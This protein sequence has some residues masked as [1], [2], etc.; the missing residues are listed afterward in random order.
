MVEK[1]E[2]KK[3]RSVIHCFDCRWWVQKEDSENLGVCYFNPPRVFN[4]SGYTA[5]RRPETSQNQFCAFAEHGWLIPIGTK[6]EV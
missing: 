5:T 1:K 2:K 6:K 4:C 3:R